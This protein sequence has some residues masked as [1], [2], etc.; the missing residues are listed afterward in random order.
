LR[1]NHSLAVSGEQL[2]PLSAPRHVA[3]AHLV[4]GAWPRVRTQTP[5]NSKSDAEDDGGVGPAAP[6]VVACISSVR[7]S[8]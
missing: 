1:L 4:F 7:V 3:L 5:A 8:L 2:R 6:G